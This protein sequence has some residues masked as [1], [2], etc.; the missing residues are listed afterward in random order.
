MTNMYKLL[1]DAHIPCVE[2]YFSNY[3][4]IEMFHQLDEVA[5]RLAHQDI[6]ICRSTL[7]VDAKLLEHSQLKILAT[8]SS[9]T[10]HIDL[11]ALNQH[12]IEFISA[13]GANAPAVCD[14]V[15]SC[16]A[17]L[18][19]K[20]FIKDKKIAIIGYGEVGKKLYKRLHTLGF[21]IGVLDPLITPPPPNAIS[22]EALKDFPILSLHT[23]FH[24]S[25]PHPSYH[26][27]NV[28][29]IQKLV[30]DVIIIN[31]ARGQIV[32]EQAI[33]S[34]HFKGIYCTDVYEH[35]PTINPEVV[36]KA[37]IATPHIAGHSIDSKR[38]ITQ[39]V[40]LAI[41]R[42]LDLKPLFETSSNPSTPIQTLENWQD[43]ALELY[44][45]EIE[46]LELKQN[47]SA[48]NFQHLRNIHNKRFDF[49][50]PQ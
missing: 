9:G 36:K 25:Q 18:N 43:D 23:N 30:D 13:K 20:G 15:T 31:A 1:I 45:P 32:E 38:R 39:Q 24:K 33:I 22:F 29:N 48:L 34:Q 41:H 28:D 49:P 50:W 17:Y 3:F 47:P 8:A 44:H 16:L 12:G 19:K 21:E 40:S 26:L 46:T 27:I 42:L 7:T 37:F 35:E 11:D 6:L 10:N 2:K 14:Y 4:Q 5:N